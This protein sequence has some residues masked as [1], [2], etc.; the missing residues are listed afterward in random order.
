MP[1][2]VTFHWIVLHRPLRVH[3]RRHLRL[4]HRLHR[5]PRHQVRRSEHDLIDRESFLVFYF[6]L[7]LFCAGSGSILGIDDLLVG[8][9]CGVGFSND[10]WF[11]QKTEEVARLQRHRPAHQPGLL[12]LLWHHHSLGAVQQPVP[13]LL[14]AWRLVSPRH[15]RHPL[16]THPHHDGPEALHPGYQDVARGAVRRPLW[17]D[18][19]RRHLRRHLARAEL[20]HGN[21]SPVRATKPG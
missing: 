6:V 11:T 12:C 9:S 14:T 13:R 10:G 3:L 20:E 18:R 5:P 2:T 7:A 17:T 8:F 16:P 4:R 19:R 21:Q 15:I 1:G